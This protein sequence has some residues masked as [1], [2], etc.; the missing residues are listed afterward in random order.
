MTHSPRL[1]SLTRLLALSATSLFGL[2]G[3]A[4]AGDVTVT[5]YGWV[6]NDA[7]SFGPF[8]G[9]SFGSG[10]VLSFDVNLPGTETVVGSEYDYDVD[11]ASV[12]MDIGG[13]VAGTFS[14]AEVLTIGND[15]PDDYFYLGG[16]LT[17][18]DFL[19]CDVDA[20]SA[21]F[22]SHDIT[23]LLGYHDVFSNQLVTDFHVTGPGG[24]LGMEVDAIEITQPLIMFA[25][26]YGDGSAGPCP[27]GNE[28]TIGAGEGCKSSLGYGAILTATGSSIVA[29]DDLVFHLSQGRPN[30]PSLLVQG[31][32]QTQTPFKDGILC[33]GNPTER[34]EV[35]PLNG[36]GSGST[37]SS[38]VTN[39]N[40]LPGI[41]RYY[42]QWYRD[43]GGVSPC[44][45]GSNFS[46]GLSIVWQA[47]GGKKK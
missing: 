15:F 28:S 22:G 18:G 23:S 35:V 27:C 37:T 1:Q 47:S 4:A 20:Q 21:L 39:G 33:M 13:P 34:V 5:V 16:A 40:V 38:I 32:V 29:N 14:G 10:A 9:A 19:S 12:S 3:S 46:N 11:L 24:F 26:C 30:Q 6:S 45:T 17:N 42:Q 43:P 25:F 44:G 41:T 31:S 2:A 7:Y 36:A 8:A